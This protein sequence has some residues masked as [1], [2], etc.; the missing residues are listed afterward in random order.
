MNIPAAV[1][2]MVDTDVDF[3]IIGGWC[4]ILHGSVRLTND[5][6]ILFRRGPDNIRR[7]V[8]AL[9]PFHPRLRDFPRDLPFVWDEK[10]VGNGTTFTLIT[11][12]GPIDLF[13]EVTGLGQ[14]EEVSAGALIVEAFGRRVR[15][16]DLK[17]L[18]QA[19]RAAGRVK[20]RLVLPELESLLEAGK[21]E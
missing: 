10:T 21:S 15:T 19:K 11:D 18:I 8:R 1:Q 7:L 16:L 12:L 3:I 6:D 13:S 4:A 9:A 20:D 14:Y 5:L 17:T 2:A